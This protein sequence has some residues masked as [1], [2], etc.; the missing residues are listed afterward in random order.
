MAGGIAARGASAPLPRGRGASLGGVPALQRG[1][2]G[3]YLSVIVLLPL[4]AVVVKSTEGGF[5]RFW[6]AVSNPEA[7]ASLKLTLIVSLIVVL[8]NAVVGTVIAW[9]LVRDDFRGKQA[10]NAL[11]DLP[12]ALPTIVAGL[13]LIAL[14]GPNG[15]APFNVGFT[16][17]GILLAL[18][19]VTLPFVVRAVQ[20]VLLE[21][22]RE[23]EEAADS[24]G[25][26]N[27][28]V[29]T[30]IIFPTLTP[31]VLAGA[32]LG[33]ARAV[34]EFGSVVLI[35]GNIPFDTQ[36]A[37]VFIFGQVESDNIIGA[38]AVAVVLL[39]ISLLVLVLLSALSHLRRR[40]DR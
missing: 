39:G 3:L 2:V 16:K 28:Q 15:P 27:R 6:D 30:R 31:A 9:V 13:T 34:G 26:T 18:L 5:S 35:S 21:L 40:H 10:V 23:V 24:L 36:V 4:S 12:F 25:A 29:F 33:F 20:P 37:P 19:F 1:L 11:I 38:S 14:Y 17:A 32:G 22:D 7:V 8:I